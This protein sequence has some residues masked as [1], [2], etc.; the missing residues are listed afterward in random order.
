MQTVNQHQQEKQQAQYAKRG[1]NKEFC[2]RTA[3][4]GNFQ[5]HFVFEELHFLPQERFH[6]KQDATDEVPP[7]RS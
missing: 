7:S 2:R 3:R 1:S 5:L 4:R 6:I